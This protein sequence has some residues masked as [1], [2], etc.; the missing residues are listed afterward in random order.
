MLSTKS[1]TPR[2]IDK[3][4]TCFGKS[5]FL[6]W[7]ALFVPPFPFAID[8]HVFSKL[9]ADAYNTRP[10]MLIPRNNWSDADIKV[11]TD[12]VNGIPEG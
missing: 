10:R 1:V 8:S 4:V 11:S 6:S 9:V 12:W 7:Q 5:P 3:N 2:K